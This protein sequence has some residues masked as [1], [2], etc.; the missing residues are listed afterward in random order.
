[1]TSHARRGALLAGNALVLLSLAGIPR[2]DPITQGDNIV[3]VAGGGPATGDGG[4]A[5]DAHLDIPSNVAFDAAGD[6]YIAETSTLASPPN[7]NHQRVRKVDRT[8]GVI[9]TVAGTGFPCPA[10]TPAPGCGDGGPATSATLAG[11]VRIVFD[12]WGNLF[13]NGG[14][15][16]NG[17]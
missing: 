3:T 6:L 7:P 1:M 10:N 9:T 17:Y 5:L 14:S 16:G 15:G 4:Q 2:A 13:I 11:P 12:R 8:T